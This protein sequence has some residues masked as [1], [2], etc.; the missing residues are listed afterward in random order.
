MGF[1]FSIGFINM[2]EQN[3][4]YKVK[5]GLEVFGHI[6]RVETGAIA[7]GVPDVNYCIEGGYEGWLELKRGSIP[8]RESTIVFKS[9]RGLEPSQVDWLLIR[10][11]VGGRCFV[12]IQLD[13]E[14]LL[15][16]GYDAARI[17]TSTIV[18]LRELAIW[19]HEGPCKQETW[20]QL[21]TCLT[22]L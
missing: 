10:S 3:L 8:A 9:Q 4:W 14:M 20:R 5:A 1:E 16:A 6:Q 17:N 7:A 2:S 22:I 21:K 11:K 13:K 18:E 12:L 15:F 19:K